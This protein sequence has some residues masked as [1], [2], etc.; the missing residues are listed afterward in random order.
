LS[1]AAV[2]K[3]L[4][5][6]RRGKVLIP[7]Q[8]AIHPKVKSGQELQAETRAEAMEEPYLLACSPWLG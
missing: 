1:L 4:L 6:T 7:L 5:K 8:V 2:L 3:L